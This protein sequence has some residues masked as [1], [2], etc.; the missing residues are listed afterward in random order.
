MDI[1][2][3]ELRGSIDRSVDVRFGGQMKDGGR[4]MRVEQAR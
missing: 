2:L 3:N 4:L 1:R